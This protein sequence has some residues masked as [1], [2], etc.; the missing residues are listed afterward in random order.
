MLR[1]ISKISIDKVASTYVGYVRNN[2]KNL[3]E[4]VDSTPP[5]QSDRKRKWVII[6][7]S[8]IGCALRCK[9]CDASMY[10]RGNLDKDEIISQIEY[11]INNHTTI[12]PHS[13]EKFKIQFARMGEPALNNA[14]IEAILDLKSR[15]PEYIPCIATT[16]PIGSEKFF[17]R[18]LSIKGQFADFQL[19]FSINSTDLYYRDKIMPFKKL[20]LNWIGRYAQK[21]YTVGKRKVVLNFALPLGA[22]MDYKII[23]RYFSPKYCIVKLTP[24]NPTKNAISSNFNISE[25]C[26]KIHSF[27]K[28]HADNL[29]KIGFQS[30]IS[31]GDMRENTVLSNC[32]QIA[33]IILMNS[34]KNHIN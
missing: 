19:Q 1:I 32:G 2:R 34:A 30:I 28:F 33:N 14:V 4:F 20:P 11:V 6:V 5:P 7:S 27:L 21:F 23:E 9:F 12:N 13:T 3:I 29:L 24:L 26:E 22:T 31:I 15:Y 16:A 8:Q 17:E 18:L 10:F 25:D